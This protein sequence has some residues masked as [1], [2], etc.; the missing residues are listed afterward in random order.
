MRILRC[1]GSKFW[2]KFQRASLK[3]NTNTTEC[4]FYGLLFCV[5]DLRY[6]RI[7]TSYALHRGAQW[8]FP[9]VTCAYN[10]ILPIIQC[11]EFPNLYLDQPIYRLHHQPIRG[12]HRQSCSHQDSGL[13]L[14][15]CPANERRRYSVTTSRIGLAQTYNQPWDCMAVSSDLCTQFLSLKSS[16]R[17][18]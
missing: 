4:A 11:E 15:L 5:C 1:M 9:S 8:K 12:P 13:S 14:C 16:I 3:F 6:L 18:K 17:G 7:V 2:V 10:N